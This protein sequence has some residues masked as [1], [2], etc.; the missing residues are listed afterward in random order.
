VGTPRSAALPT[1][2]ST[3]GDG[4]LAAYAAEIAALRREGATRSLAISAMESLFALGF[5]R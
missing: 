5:S 2:R 3:A 1:L 4:A